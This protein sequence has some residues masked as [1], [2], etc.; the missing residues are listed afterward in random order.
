M[1]TFTLMFWVFFLLFNILSVSLLY[2]TKGCI[3]L[4][5]QIACGFGMFIT[6]KIGRKFLGIL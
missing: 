6:S 3:I 5:I 2:H 4:Y 1:D